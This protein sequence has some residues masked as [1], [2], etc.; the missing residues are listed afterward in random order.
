MSEKKTLH[1]V[2]LIQDKV[3]IDES[4]D[5]VPVDD[6]DDSEIK[7]KYFAGLA[8]SEVTGNQVSRFEP[9]SA[10]TKVYKNE[11]G[12][13]IGARMADKY[14]ESPFITPVFVEYAEFDVPEEPTKDIAPAQKESPAPAPLADV[15]ESERA[16]WIALDKLCGNYPLMLRKKVGT[17]FR[18]AIA[19]NQQ[20][21]RY[22][23][24]DEIFA[25][26]RYFE[27]C[28]S[29][30]VGRIRNRRIAEGKDPDG[31]DDWKKGSR[32]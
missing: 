10:A 23:P 18:F 21:I 27:E 28:T 16:G 13:K 15:P 20:D 2:W 29:F 9:L 32:A 12:A 4:A 25:W 19:F 6:S 14:Y 22:L 26:T 3:P 8:I 17:V 5:N 24:A 31:A 1:N 11:K 7:P 30:V